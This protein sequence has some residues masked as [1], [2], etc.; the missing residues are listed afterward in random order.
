MKVG[1]PAGKWIKMW[2]S[3]TKCCSVGTHAENVNYSAVTPYSYKEAAVVATQNNNTCKDRNYL[4]SPAHARLVISI[5]IAMTVKYEIIIV[6]IN[7]V[8]F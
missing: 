1:R 5:T 4:L 8:I 3:P 7:R 2:A 6:L